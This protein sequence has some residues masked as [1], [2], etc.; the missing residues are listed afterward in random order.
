MPRLQISDSFHPLCPLRFIAVSD[1]KESFDSLMLADFEAVSRGCWAPN[2]MDLKQ[3]MLHSNE[4]IP[5]V[6]NGLSKEVKR[7]HKDM[8]LNLAPTLRVKVEAIELG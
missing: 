3:L 6:V 4:S 1:N 7:V 2:G 5:S 8:L